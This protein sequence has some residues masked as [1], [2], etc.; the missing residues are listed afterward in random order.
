LGI[1]RDQ[2]IGGKIP[3]DLEKVKRNLEQHGLYVSLVHP[4]VLWVAAN[5]EIAPEDGIHFA[6]SACDVEMDN[7]IWIARFHVRPPFTC[8]IRG[9]PSEIESLVARPGNPKGSTTTHGF[10]L[11]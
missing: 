6:K 10:L 3:H 2:R 11:Y 1:E 8:T 7:G 5:V 4:N 9:A